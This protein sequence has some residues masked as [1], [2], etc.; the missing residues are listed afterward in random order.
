MA[1]KDEAKIILGAV[2]ENTA[3]WAKETYEV[4]EKMSAKG[5]KISD[6]VSSL[7]H[8]KE[9]KKRMAELCSLIAGETIT[10]ESDEELT[11]KPMIALMITK[12]TDKHKHTYETNKV[13]ISLGDGTA[14]DENGKVGSPI[15][16]TRAILRPATEKECNDMITPAQIKGLQKEVNI[17]FA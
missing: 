10:I 8:G 16:P 17:V 12:L 14:V 4:E 6:V 11:F 1:K 5:K 15:P 7:S 9:D 13:V 3:E 2:V